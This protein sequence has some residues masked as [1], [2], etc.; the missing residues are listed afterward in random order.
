MLSIVYCEYSSL[1]PFKDGDTW[2]A[3]FSSVYLVFICVASAWGTAVCTGSC[4]SQLSCGAQVPGTFSRVSLSL[5]LTNYTSCRWPSGLPG[6]ACLCLAE[7]SNPHVCKVSIL[8]TGLTLPPSPLI[9]LV[10]QGPR[11]V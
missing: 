4:G 6:F 8:P 7:N 10:R 1:S 5:E 11:V 3:H 2:K 9:N